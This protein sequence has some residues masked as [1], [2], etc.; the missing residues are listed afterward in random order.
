MRETETQHSSCCFHSG[1]RSDDG[2]Q[3]HVSYQSF[4][5]LIRWGCQETPPHSGCTTE[6]QTKHA[7]EHDSAVSN[8]KQ[9]H[10]PPRVF[11]AGNP[12]RQNDPPADS[13]KPQ[14]KTHIWTSGVSV[15][16]ST[17]LMRSRAS[18]VR[19]GGRLSLHFRILSIVFFLFSA[20]NGGWRKI[21]GKSGLLVAVTC[22]Q[23]FKPTTVWRK[24]NHDGC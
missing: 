17:F 13:V 6:S 19:Y 21:R 9:A 4:Q 22:P 18:M 3:I 7:S 16:F 14:N 23:G 10:Y 5:H 20:V 8:S 11:P 12:T 1:V 2:K 15:C 24:R